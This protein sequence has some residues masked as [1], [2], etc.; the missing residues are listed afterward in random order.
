MVDKMEAKN[1]Y[2]SLCNFKEVPSHPNMLVT[3]LAGEAAKVA[4][5]IDDDEVITTITDVLRSF[6]GDPGTCQVDF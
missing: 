4:D 2:R 6:T 5:K 3:W 1:W